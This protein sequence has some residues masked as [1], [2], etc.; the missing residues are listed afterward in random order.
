MWIEHMRYTYARVAFGIATA[1]R[2]P[3]LST[4]PATWTND[5]GISYW[6]LSNRIVRIWDRRTVLGLKIPD[7]EIDL[8]IRGRR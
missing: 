7:T 4:R 3:W 5:D 6:I 2:G 1:Q 8:Q